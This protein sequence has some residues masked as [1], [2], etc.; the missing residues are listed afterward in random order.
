MPTGIP[1]C[2]EVWNMCVGCTK[3]KS[4]C[5]FCWAEKLHSQ[6]QRAYSAGKH[7]P[8]QYAYPFSVVRCLSDRLEQPLHWRKPRTIFVNSM[9][10]TFHEDV[11]FEFVLRL[12]GIT[13]LTPWH[14][15]LFFT[16]RY[17]R[18]LA[19]F[20]WWR[21]K[22]RES[23]ELYGAKSLALQAVE[24][25]GSKVLRTSAT[26]YWEDNYDQSDRGI[27]D[28]PIPWPQPNVHLYFSAST[29]AEV[30]EAVPILLDIPVAVRGLSLEPL[31]GTIDL[32]QID[33][34]RTWPFRA[35]TSKH[36][37]LRGFTSSRRQLGDGCRFMDTHTPNL[38]HIIVGCE[39]GPNRRPCKIEWIESVV[40][41]CKDAGVPVYVKQIDTTDLVPPGVLNNKVSTKPVEWPKCLRVQEMPK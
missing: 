36:D 18:V 41:Q 25:L 29:Q 5:K 28:Y 12:L 11:P 9:S 32:T 19:F 35:E 31:L 22:T 37:T 16:K 26:K 10:D 7:L 27:L 13:M 39:S 15:Y 33:T 23:H 24:S 14:T 34:G 1:Y 30:D 21:D 2:D 20:D 40:N 4:G 17:D 8:L 6:R 38:G 3:I